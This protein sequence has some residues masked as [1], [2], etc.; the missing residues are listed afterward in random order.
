LAW[1]G[2]DE[3][4][5]AGN[6]RGQNFLILKHL[7]VRSRGS[8]TGGGL[9]AGLRWRHRR[10][11]SYKGSAADLVYS[12]IP[13][14]GSWPEVYIPQNDRAHDG[15]DQGYHYRHYRAAR[16]HPMSPTSMLRDGYQS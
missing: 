13:N 16:L 5:V 14:G 15:D 8:T 1:R 6:G 11:S 4:V 9:F 12:V 7:W 3:A 2:V 10:T